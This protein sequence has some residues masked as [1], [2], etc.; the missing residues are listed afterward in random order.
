MK[1][2]KHYLT[3]ALMSTSMILLVT[4]QVLW[5]RNSY[6]KA[7]EDLRG[8]TG[9][10]LRETVMAL[11]DSM[12]LQNIETTPL[13]SGGTITYS[14]RRDTTVVLLGGTPPP[15]Q[16]DGQVQ[17]FIS[18]TSEKDSIHQVLRSVASR[19]NEGDIRPNTRFTVRLRNDSL[20]LDSIQRGLQRQLEKAGISTPAKVSKRG[21]FPPL[22]PD[23]R[24]QIRMRRMADPENESERERSYFGTELRTYWV[25]V[26]PFFGYS[27]TLTEVRPHLFREIMP[28]ILFSGVLTLITLGAF[29]VMYRSLRSQQRLMALKN[30][31]ISN[32]T[33]ELKTP[34]ATVSVALEA[35]KNFRGI[36]NP[37]LTAE[38]LDI[39]QFELQR[40]SLLADKVLTTSLFDER[41]VTLDMAPVPVD[42]M[43]T[44]ILNSMKLVLDKSGAT[45]SFEKK[46]DHFTVEG[47]AVHLTN[48]IYNLLDNALKYS[49][50][51][52]EITVLLSDLGSTVS[53][54]VS[55]KG[56]GI[57]TEFQ[58]RIFERFFRLPTGDVHN[59][60]GHGLGLSYVDQVVKK[61][62][63][64]I[65]VTSAP[66]KGST[67]TVM[68]PKQHS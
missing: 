3:L 16:T 12:L 49:P 11:R 15:K 61:H 43:V 14:K 28:Q 62:G 17:V 29:V 18:S 50:E 64:S 10:L 67:F 54:A 22:P 34:I 20:S 57:P 59:I 33:H 7:A 39:A 48:V 66:G 23:G 65:T 25:R 2:T 58:S 26:D 63:G 6:Q 53:L 21:S 44:T 42:E 32:M 40:L 52:P 9:R 13:D 37:K 5:L 55:D 56:L 46:G 1:A 30:D 38:Y 68:L 4:L 19:I 51:K 27:A 35:L 8:D 45:L 36:D 41:G 31:F 60:K 24:G 47:S